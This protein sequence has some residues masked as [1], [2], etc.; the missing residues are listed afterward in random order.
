MAP[1]TDAPR[2]TPFGRAAAHVVA[3]LV[4]AA[5]AETKQTAAAGRALT[6]LF[7]PPV[8]RRRATVRTSHPP[9]PVTP[10]PRGADGAVFPDAIAHLPL[11]TQSKADI[12][13]V[14]DIA[15]LRARSNV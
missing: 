4:V 1:T 10:P 13:P 11:H 7:R 8:R 15:R 14:R 2:R 12:A 5:T 3:S 6:A 9:P